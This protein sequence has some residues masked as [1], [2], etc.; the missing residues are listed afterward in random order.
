LRR[1]EGGS[2]VANLWHMV[3][4]ADS[5]AEVW[6][7]NYRIIL[8]RL[9][10][11]EARVKEAHMVNRECERA[12][13]RAMSERS[14]EYHVALNRLAG[15]ETRIAELEKQLDACRNVLKGQMHGPDDVGVKSDGAA[16][17]CLVP[18]GFHKAQRDMGGPPKARPGDGSE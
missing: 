17:A 9:V 2:E 11:T 10:D 18:T 8:K 3:K 7:G 1:G 12:R 13:D 14:T 15:T 4:I 16:D 6:E 5:K